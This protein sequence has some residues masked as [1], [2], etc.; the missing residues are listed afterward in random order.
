MNLV[1]KQESLHV[2]SAI[3]PHKHLVVATI[4]VLTLFRP[5]FSGIA[6]AKTLYI[7]VSPVLSFAT[8]FVV[9]KSTLAFED[10]AIG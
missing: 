10:V 9:H 1:R 3:E 5:E 7:R 8:I 2:F 4:T 6:T